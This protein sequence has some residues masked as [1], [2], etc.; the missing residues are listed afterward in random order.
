MKSNKKCTVSISFHLSLACS[1]EGKNKMPTFSHYLKQSKCS[2][3]S[4][5]KILVIF[6]SFFEYSY[7]FLYNEYIAIFSVNNHVRYNLSLIKIFF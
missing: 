3:I 1:R 7:N 2:F 6:P 4:Y 5:D